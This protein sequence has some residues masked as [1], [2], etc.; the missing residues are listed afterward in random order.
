MIISLGIPFFIPKDLS[1]GYGFNLQLFPL[2]DLNDIDEFERIGK[3]TEKLSFG[4]EFDED[5]NFS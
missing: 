4:S 1:F 3:I 2:T 5:D